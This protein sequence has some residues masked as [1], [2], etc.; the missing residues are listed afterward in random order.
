MPDQL[1][2]LVRAVKVALARHHRLILICPWPPGVPTPDKHDEITGERRSYANL[3]YVKLVRDTTTMRFHRAYH[4][5][6]QTFGGLGVP[7][8]CAADGDPARVILDRLETLRDL[9][10]KR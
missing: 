5:V 3:D 2:P 6:R 9:G 7:V 4:R 1:P 8:V 10:G